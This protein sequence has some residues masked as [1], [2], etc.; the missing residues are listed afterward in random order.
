MLRP[1]PAR[2]PSPGRRDRMAFDVRE[3]YTKF[4]HQVPMRDGVRLFTSILVPKDDSTPYPILLTRSP[5]GIGPYGPDEFFPIGKQ[6]EALLQAGYV[7]VRQD[8]R[9]RL[10]SEGRFTHVRPHQP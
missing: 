2:P 5:F 4:E 7:F 8:V 1:R 9:G 10:M 3:H 6:T